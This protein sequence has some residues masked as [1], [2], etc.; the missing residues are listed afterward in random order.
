M[1]DHHNSL[2]PSPVGRGEKGRDERVRGFFD[3]GP[4]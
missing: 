4:A 3:F 2:L 1:T